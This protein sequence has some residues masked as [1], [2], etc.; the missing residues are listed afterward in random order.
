MD[1]VQKMKERSIKYEE[2]FRKYLFSFD[3]ET[4]KKILEVIGLKK[5]MKNE[6]WNN[7]ETKEANI[8]SKKMCE[9]KNCRSKDIYISYYGRDVCERCWIKHCDGKINLKNEFKITTDVEV[10]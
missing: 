8:S 1:E 7:K 10:I 6:F 3:Y 2:K 5:V 4:H 9:I